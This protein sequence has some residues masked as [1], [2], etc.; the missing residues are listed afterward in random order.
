MTRMLASVANA[1]EADVVL[2]HGAD[3]IDLKDP[4]RGALGA[5]PLET[6]PRY[7]TICREATRDERDARRPALQ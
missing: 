6:A 4:G 2:R 3:V 1:A 7:D 5:V